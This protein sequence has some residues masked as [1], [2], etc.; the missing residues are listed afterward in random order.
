ML[1]NLQE[2]STTS[3][4]LDKDVHLP[5]TSKYRLM[6][7]IAEE[8]PLWRDRKDRPLVTAENALTSQLCGHLNSAAR[9]SP[10]WD[11]LQFRVE[12]PDEIKKGRK[13]DLVP[14]P[15]GVTVWIEGCRHS[16]F[17]II[18]PIECKRLPTPQG[19]DRDEREYV[20]SKFSST[21]GIQ[22][23]KSA[24][25]GAGHSVGAMIAYVQ[26]ESPTTWIERIAGWINDLI[27]SGA[28]GWS[29]SDLLTLESDDTA[30]GLTIFQSSHSRTGKMG[31]ITLRHLWLSMN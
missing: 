4:T 17:D 6:D 5:A 18:L 11:F 15:C 9:R 26:D 8:L 29:S 2:D 27:N 3:G 30:R 1:A 10:G 25:H 20:N 7:F 14:S 12:E 24:H 19:T 22:R 16:D 28:F 13:I 23:F 31:K 21:G